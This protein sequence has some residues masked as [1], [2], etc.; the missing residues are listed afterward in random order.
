M[1]HEADTARGTTTASSDETLADGRALERVAAK[2]DVFGEYRL[3][4]VLGQGAMGMVYRAYDPR[5]DRL[6][7]LKLVH[8]SRVGANASQASAR[9]VAEA[10]ALARVSHPNVLSIYDIGT[11][12]EL[13]YVALELVEGVDLAQWLR[14][15]KRSWTTIVDVFIAVASGLAAVHAAGLVHRDVKPANILVE[16]L[17]PGDTMGRVLVADFGIARATTATPVP[18]IA[19]EADASTED[20]HL[21]ATGRVVGTP[22]YM[23]PEQHTGGEIGPAADQYAVCVALYEALFGQRPFLGG[24]QAMLLAKADPPRARP[25]GD[26]PKWLWAIVRRGLS[27]R[28]RDRFASME[29]LAAALSDGSVLRRWRWPAAL[30]ASAIATTAMAVALMEPACAGADAKLGGVWN[31]DRREAIAAAFAA[32]ERPGADGAWAEVSTRVDEYTAQLDD[33]YHEACEAALV[34]RDHAEDL[35]DRRLACLDQRKQVLERSLALLATGDAD[36][37]DHAGEVAS[38][39]G[40]IEPCADLEALAAGIAPPLPAQRSSVEEV[41]R[42]LADASA[43]S[44][45]GRFEDASRSIEGAVTLARHVGY[46]RATVEALVYAAELHERQSRVDEA[47]VALDEA[48]ETGLA[49]GSDAFVLRALVLRTWI[50]AEYERDIDAALR[51]AALGRAQLERLGDPREQA[52]GLHNALGTAFAAVG[53][54]DEAIAELEQ[55]LKRIEGDHTMARWSAI[56]RSNIGGVRFNAGDLEQAQADYELA[57]A[58][59]RSLHGDDHPEVA[60]TALRV[61]QVQGQRGLNVEAIAGLRGAIAALERL[62]ATPTELATALVSLGTMLRNSGE[63]DDAGRTYLR[64]VELL[65][66]EGDDF[67]LAYALVNYGHSCID[68]G[69]Y[70]AA[71]VQLQRAAKLLE[72]VEPTGQNLAHAWL[73]LGW[74]RERQGKADEALSF[75]RRAIEVAPHTRSAA[76][77]LGASALV[78]ARAGRDAEAAA[79][80]QRQ[81]EILAS[82]TLVFASDRLAASIAHVCVATEMGRA[83]EAADAI[84]MLE[85]LLVDGRRTGTRLAGEAELAIGRARLERGEDALARAALERAAADLEGKHRADLVQQ[86]HDAEAVLEGRERRAR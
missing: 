14:A 39:L 47:R 50:A 51:W 12:H 3:L 82:D 31:D 36:V 71:E 23:A 27:S 54:Y 68:R 40:A 76:R 32:S 7:A 73:G 78:L 60:N 13:V 16:R 35:Y 25:R 33:A 81:D 75:H 10:R 15:G 67:T 59:L 84:A 79:A 70:D 4:D 74:I 44:A 37:V 41:R 5:L 62:Q 38:T 86:L 29:Q 69:I 43:L 24:A 42:I 17:L 55:G 77:A 26:V 56:L 22:A 20:M 9:L 1:N 52:L 8:P 49:I 2:G 19:V 30:G 46:A 28:P 18:S 45:A 58:S 65:D 11:E 85:R 63:D 21:T 66:G 57:L 34:R 83:G 48:I 72:P 61:A 6:V 64:A 53:R 80:L